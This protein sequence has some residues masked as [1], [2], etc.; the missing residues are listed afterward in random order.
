M[1]QD[2]A[3]SRLR[4]TLSIRQFSSE[5]REENLSAIKVALDELV[6]AQ[7]TIAM[8]C[9]CLGIPLDSSGGRIRDA[10]RSQSP[11]WPFRGEDI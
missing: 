1:D 10:L 7:N 5:Y 3:V 11:D 4:R 6:E 8:I 2:E 9:R